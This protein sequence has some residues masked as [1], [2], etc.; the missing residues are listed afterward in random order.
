VLHVASKA[1]LESLRT[2]L[3]LRSLAGVQMFTKRR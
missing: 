3:R 2:S 1:G